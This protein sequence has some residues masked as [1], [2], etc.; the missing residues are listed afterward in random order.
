MNGLPDGWRSETLGEITDG[1]LFCDGDWVETKDQ[2]PNGTVRLTQLADVGVAEFRD[3]SDRWL[4]DDQAARLGC[5]FLAPGDILIA[6]M[7]DPLGRACVVP[8]RIGRAVTVVDVAIARP[9]R[10]D[11]DPRYVMWALNGPVAQRQIGSMQSG[12]TRKRISRKNLSKVR[13]P[14]PRIGE[15]RRIVD[16]LEDHLSR[17]DAAGAAVTTAARRTEML[18][19]ATA[20]RWTLQ[21]SAPVRDVPLADLLTEY[22]GGVWGDPPGTHPLDVDV[23][24]VTELKPWGVIEPS[25]AARRSVPRSHLERRALRGGDLLLEKS[26]GGITTP[27]GRVG[28]VPDVTGDVVCSNF[29]QLMRPDPRLVHP[30]YLHLLLNAM[31]AAGR[32][33][34]LQ[35]ASTNLRNIK[36]S[37]YARLQVSLPGLQEQLEAVH[38]VEAVWDGSAGLAAAITG[39]QQRLAT[40]RRALL[41]AAFSGRLTGRSSDLDL[42]EELIDA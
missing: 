9:S 2:D 28:L 6:R 15:Q 26:G 35:K 8:D 3:R 7:P 42:A 10:S 13:L 24:R 14:L 33:E 31:Q 18:R 4:R 12:T 20:A 17:L 30:R 16:I 21:P 27:I 36:T 19:W 23:I 37:E 5:T 34:H 32:T 39:G 29:M 25:T 41:A 38:R 11:V 40:L 1:G 22:V